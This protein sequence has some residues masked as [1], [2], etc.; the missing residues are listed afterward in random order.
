MKKV[1]YTDKVL[2]GTVSRFELTGLKVPA[3]RS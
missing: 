2:A 3:V 1:Y